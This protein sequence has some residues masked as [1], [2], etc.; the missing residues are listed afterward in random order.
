[1]KNA[2]SRP[3]TVVFTRISVPRRPRRAKMMIAMPVTNIASVESMNG[4]PRMAP[5]PTACE[6]SV[7]TP[8]RRTGPRIA[9]TGMSVSGMAVATAAR[10]LPTAPS[11]RFSL[12]PSHSMPFVKSSAAIRMITSEP[13]SRTMSTGKPNLRSTPR[14]PARAVAMGPKV[15]PDRCTGRP[16]PPDG[17][18]SAVLTMAPVWGYSPSGA[19]SVAERADAV[20]SPLRRPRPRPGSRR[21]TRGRPATSRADA[22]PR[23]ARR[24]ARRRRSRSSAAA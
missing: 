11:A 10:T 7:A 14:Q 19:R 18:R 4:A 8:P 23:S 1:M 3:R 2:T 13:T 15:S 6:L 21:A 24:R 20:N 5:T 12:W 22:A 16:E 17:A 9:I